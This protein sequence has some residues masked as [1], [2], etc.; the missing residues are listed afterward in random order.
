MELPAAEVYLARDDEH[1]NLAF[2]V[3]QRLA[4]LIAIF[5]S[6]SSAD[7][8]ST[9]LLPLDAARHA[10]ALAA[11]GAT[12]DV[13]NVDDLDEDRALAREQGGA[14]RSVGGGEHDLG[15]EERDLGAEEHE[16][17]AQ[18]AS[19]AE[20]NES[21]GAP[22]VRDGKYENQEGDL[23]MD[24]PMQ[25]DLNCIDTVYEPEHKSNNILEKFRGVPAGYGGRIVR[26]AQV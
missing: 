22:A 20:E 10:A 14:R 6:I 23:V 12:N 21:A 8:S 13:S 5:D 11:A 24:R 4:S 26:I 19:A 1:S 25:L 17:D 15:A 3:G 18:D 16:L 2:R 7:V 9:H